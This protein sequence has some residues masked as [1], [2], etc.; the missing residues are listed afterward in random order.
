MFKTHNL[1]YIGTFVCFCTFRRGYESDLKSYVTYTFTSDEIHT[2]D[3]PDAKQA[4]GRV[5][6]PSL[7]NQSNTKLSTESIPSSTEDSRLPK[8]SDHIEYQKLLH[9]MESVSES[10][11]NSQKKLLQTIQWTVEQEKRTKRD[12]SEEYTWN[13]CRYEALYVDYSPKIPEVGVDIFWHWSDV[14][15]HIKRVLENGLNLLYRQ[16]YVRFLSL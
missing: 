14:V 10:D 7:P 16:R 3:K 9:D 6:V 13:Y 15:Q 8:K 2:V 12:L 1:C 11:L 4:G 5:S